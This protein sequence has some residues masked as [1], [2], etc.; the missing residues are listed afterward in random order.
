MKNLLYKDLVLGVPP[1]FYFMPVLTGA[2]MLI[3]NWLYLVVLMYFFFIT[4]P[5]TFASFRANNDMTFSVLMPVKKSDIVKA[6]MTAFIL[7]ELLHVVVAVPFGLINLHLYRN[8]YR[9]FLIPNFAYW[10]IAFVMLGI[11]NIVFFPI[12][13]KTGYKY[14]VAT[15]AATVAIISFSAG[16][17]LLNVYNLSVRERLT[18]VGITADHLVLFT[19]GIAIYS[20]FSIIAYRLSNAFFEKVD[21]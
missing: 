1:F 15:I 21:I 14:G 13:F 7:L 5:N 2:L 16:V 18:H 6:R 17:E 9:L 11:F 10:G 8:F 4:V 3:P 12:Y 20:I 19:L